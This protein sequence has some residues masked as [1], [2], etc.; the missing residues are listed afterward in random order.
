MIFS[1]DFITTWDDVKIDHNG[2]GCLSYWEEL[3]CGIYSMHV[4][5]S[6]SRV[7]LAVI[8]GIRQEKFVP[9]TILF[10][11]GLDSMILAALLDK[12]LD[13]SCE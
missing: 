7:Y 3:P 4:G 12:C 10:F 13:L 11:A 8:S 2:I 5:A 1:S 9:M 6:K